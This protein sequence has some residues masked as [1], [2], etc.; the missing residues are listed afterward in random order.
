MEIFKKRLAWSGILLFGMPLMGMPSAFA[1]KPINLEHQKLSTLQAIVSSPSSGTEIREISRATG[2]TNILHVRVQQ[3]YSGY[4][5]W[6]AD[7]VI[8]IPNGSKRLKS[9]NLQHLTSGNGSMNGVIYQDIDKDLAKTRSFINSAAQADKAMTTAI[10]TFTKKAGGTANISD[11]KVSQLVFIDNQNKAHWAFLVSFHADALKA[12]ELPSKPNYIMDAETMQVYA[13]W[14]NIKTVGDKTNGEVDGGGFGGNKKM[15]KLVYDSQQGDLHYAKLLVK[16]DETSK[17]CSME[18]S[19]VV[20]RN[21][22][23]GKIMSFKCS[24]PDVDHA[25]LFWDGDQDAVN[26]GYSPSNDALFGG[27]VI[28]GMYRDW[29][30]VPVLTEEDGTPMILTMV[31]HDP[32]DNAYWDGRKMTFGD[33]V[34]M[35]YP[36]TS[37]GVAAHEISHGFTEQHSGLAYYAQSGGMNEAFSDMAAQAAEYY[38]YNGKNSWQIGPEIFKAEDEALRYMDQ[39]SKDCGSRSPGNWCSIDTAD[40]YYSGLDVHYSSGVYNRAFYLMGTADGWNTRKAFD[41]MVNANENYWTSNSTFSQGAC[42]VISSAKELGYDVEAVKSAFE[43]VKV[44]TSS[45]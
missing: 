20:V 3:M 27:Q 39:P 10:A 12:G 13:E 38:A 32:I 5:V 36:L 42:G 44:D 2:K 17:T 22:R 29:Y 30:N 4:K 19:D 9:A 28:K 8:H 16:R 15:G 24:A 40:Q 34:S 1:A 35:F 43:T 6:G 26:E 18:N 23:G 21:Y 37:L 31:V 11:K 45:C 14:N 33:G 7:A 25:G 41:V